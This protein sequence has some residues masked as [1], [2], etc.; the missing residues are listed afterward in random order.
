MSEPAIEL[1]DVSVAI[2]EKTVLD[3]IN[4]AVDRGEMLGII[5]PNGAGKTTLLHL[6]NG[7]RH[8]TSG[9]ITVLGCE[10]SSL[11]SA[12]LARLRHT[13][14]FVP[15]LPPHDTCVPISARQ[16]VEIARTARAGLFRRLGT[17][18]RQIIDKWLKRLGI[19]D[20][21]DRAFPSLSG[22]EQRKVHLAR[23]LAQ[24]PE[25]ILLDEPASNLDIYWQEELTSLIEE[26]WRATGL[27]VVMVTHEVQ[28]LPAS[29]ARIAL[30][31]DGRIKGIG[32]PD[33]VFRNDLLREVFGSEVEIAKRNGR[34][35]LLPL[36]RG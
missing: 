26:L 25:I 5:G 1:R 23:A 21:A 33:D 20:F 17:E 14:G 22:G 3:G 29:C 18:D 36:K 32:K 7:L 12:E 16:V 15:Q 28:H 9:S 31:S 2:G 27:T 34:F 8:P 10:L 13:I 35:Y 4:L 24:E 6:M 30:L 19:S 11:N